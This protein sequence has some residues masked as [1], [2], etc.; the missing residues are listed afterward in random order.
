MRLGA[1]TDR[2]A[3]RSVGLADPVGAH[4]HAAAGEVRALDVLHQP[5]GVDRRVVDEGAGGGD[6]L[7]QVVGRDVRRHADRDPGGA[8]DEQV[9]EARRQDERLGRGL[10][11]VGAE[12]DG[13]GLDVAQHLGREA[14][15]A[16]LGVAHRGGGVVVD[17]AEVALAVDER[18]AQRELLRHPDQRVVDRRSRREGGTCPSPRR[19]CRR[20][21]GTPGSAAGR[22]RASRRARGGGRA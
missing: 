18:V 7:G 3:A 14:L 2:A 16:G 10:V 6:H 8:V 15:E 1:D 12:V 5:L 9:R 4:D 19:R 21:C 13:V 17:R 22:G 11:V 20:T